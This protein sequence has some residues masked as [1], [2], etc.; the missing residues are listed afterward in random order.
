MF[1]V[2]NKSI[3][4]VQ[5][6]SVKSRTASIRNR[7]LSSGVGPQPRLIEVR[8]SASLLRE[9]TEISDE[10]WVIWI[11]LQALAGPQVSSFLCWLCT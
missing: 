5:F 6:S 11:S 7:G 10:Y 2:K 4:S 9:S 8:R 1:L 3:H